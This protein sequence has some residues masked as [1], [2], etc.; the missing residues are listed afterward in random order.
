MRGS[1][2]PI[3]AESCEN[4]ICEL[5][6]SRTLELPAIFL[7]RAC[8]YRIIVMASAFYHVQS[9]CFYLLVSE[10]GIFEW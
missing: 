7:A 6:C 8:D 1:L 3:G 4:E 5:K 2:A 10:D 9:Y